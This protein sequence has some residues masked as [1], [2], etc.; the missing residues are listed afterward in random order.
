MS[1]DNN[2]MFSDSRNTLL[3]FPNDVHTFYAKR[4]RNNC[5]QFENE[6]MRA[7]NVATVHDITRSLAAGSV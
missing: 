2:W 5:K 6:R 1:E 7:Q 3:H 4:V